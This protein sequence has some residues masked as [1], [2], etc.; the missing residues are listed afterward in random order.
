MFGLYDEQTY[1]DIK[2]FVISVSYP[3]N[4]ILMTNIGTVVYGMNISMSEEA[5][6][7]ANLELYRPKL[8][9]V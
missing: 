6:I 8:V 7:L 3:Y 1:G 9:R 5:K 4:I 2:I